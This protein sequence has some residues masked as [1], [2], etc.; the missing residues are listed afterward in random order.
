M[1]RPWF[2]AWSHC[3]TKS[4][5]STSVHNGC[6]WAAC[7]TSY[8]DTAELGC[9]DCWVCR[10]WKHH[11]AHPNP[12]QHEGTSQ[13]TSESSVDRSPMTSSGQSGSD[14]LAC[15]KHPAIGSAKQ[16]TE[17]NVISFAGKEVLQ[18]KSEGI[19][20]DIRPSAV[21]DRTKHHRVLRCIP[22]RSLGYNGDTNKWRNG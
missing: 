5:S 22:V 21:K 4:S 2:L 6:V 1:H 14:V 8:T 20:H 3:Y 15:Q 7:F 13:I 17:T 12:S 10:T 11:T 9:W 16:H 19:I 18:S